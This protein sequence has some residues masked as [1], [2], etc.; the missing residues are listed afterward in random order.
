MRRLALAAL[1]VSGLAFSCGK[2]D[3]TVENQRTA[4]GTPPAGGGEFHPE[5]PYVLRGRWTLPMESQGGGDA[6]AMLLGTGNASNPITATVAPKVTF[7]VA[8][9]NFVAPAPVDLASYGSLDVTDLRDNNLDVCGPAG[10]AAC[11]TAVLRIYSS[12]TPGA[13]LWNAA[14]AYGLP[15][16]TGTN[17][18][19]LDAAGARVVATLALANKVT[20]KLKDF[21]TAARFQVP[22]A[23]DFGNAAAGAYRSTLV[24]E[25]LL[26]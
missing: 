1:L 10:T 26:Q 11:T 8:T 17:V 19:G 22:V 9:D 7:V 24:V 12:G 25:Y 23:V 21:T 5:D 16:M 6:A 13:G 15:I 20:V 3:K 18:I 2:D 4:A 14:K